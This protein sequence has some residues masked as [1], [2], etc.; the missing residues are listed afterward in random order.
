MTSIDDSDPWWAAFSGVCKD[1][2]LTLEPEIFPAATDSRY[3]RLVRGL[4]WV[5]RGVGGPGCWLSS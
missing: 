1:M 3:L 4:Q 2:N 5:G